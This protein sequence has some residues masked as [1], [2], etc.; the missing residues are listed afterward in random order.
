MFV[1]LSTHIKLIS[2]FFQSVGEPVRATIASLSRD[3]VIFIPLVLILGSVMGVTGPLW[4]GPVADLIGFIISSIMVIQFMHK[5]PISMK[6]FHDDKVIQDSKK[7]VIVTISREHGTAGKYIGELVANKLHIPYYYKELTALAAKESGL[8]QE[9]LSK[10]HDEETGMNEVYLTST[11]AKYATIAQ[12]KVIREI[13][14]HGSCVIVGRAADYILRDY[15][16]VVR[17]FIYADDDYKI[18]KIKEM[19]HD[20][21][22]NA[23]KNMKKS[24]KNRATYYS[25]ISGT[26]WGDYKNYDLMINAS[27]GTE[28]TANMIIDYI[29][30][31]EKK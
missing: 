11:P 10:F 3:I 14:D 5:L 25:M 9:F 21:D 4:A 18:N 30:K 31:R 27:I 29:K 16:D 13:A 2:I 17:V 8:S 15:D 22:K 1:I 26:S 6:E 23:L 7:G 19:Y 12:E 24:N 20:N 28:E